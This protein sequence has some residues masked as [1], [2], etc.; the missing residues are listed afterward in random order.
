MTITWPTSGTT[1]CH[2]ATRAVGEAAGPAGLD[3][4]LA[5]GLRRRAYLEAPGV[6]YEHAGNDECVVSFAVRVAC[7]DAAAAA[8][9]AASVAASTARVGSLGLGSLTL[10]DAGLR[11]C[12]PVVAGIAVRV[13]YQFAG[14]AVPTAAP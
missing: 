9:L 11:R 2:G 10:Q 4:D 7:A 12:R 5:P 1:I 13:E 6:A 14:Y 8:A 3:I